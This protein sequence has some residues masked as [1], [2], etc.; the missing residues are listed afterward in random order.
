VRRALTK[1]TGPMGYRAYSATPGI[2]VVS[3]AKAWMVE[4]EYDASKVSEEHVRNVDI[5][6]IK[7]NRH[8][9][10]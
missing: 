9:T 3:P 1:V 8:D 2:L 7:E 5:R 6:F 10:N 4:I